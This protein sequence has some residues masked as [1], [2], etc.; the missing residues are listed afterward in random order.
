MV[1]MAPDQPLAG[2]LRPAGELQMG[3]PERM[4]LFIGS[5]HRPGREA[6]AQG[7]QEED[8]VTRM[9]HAHGFP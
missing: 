6:E 4:L 2:C 8:E 9:A 5:T 1:A 7:G 3:A